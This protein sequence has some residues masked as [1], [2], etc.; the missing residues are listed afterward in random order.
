MQTPNILSIV[1][2]SATEAQSFVTNTAAPSVQQ[3]W[4]DSGKEQAKAIALWLWAVAQTLAF[5]IVV[6][7]VTIGICLFRIAQ[8]I[9][10]NRSAIKKEVC[11]YHFNVWAAI[12][13]HATLFCDRYIW[14][15]GDFAEVLIWGA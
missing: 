5:I 2:T 1:K 15:I 7:T 14:P 13:H 8:A 4:A 9:W 3:W 6:S 10:Q 12:Q 11:A